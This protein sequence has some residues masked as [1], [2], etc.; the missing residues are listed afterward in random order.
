MSEIPEQE[1][2][3]FASP[4]RAADSSP[5]AKVKFFVRVALLLITFALVGGSGWWFADSYYDEQDGPSLTAKVRRGD[6]QVTVLEQGTLESSE[7]TEV[8]CRIRGWSKVTWIV[9][10]GAEVQ[11]GEELVRID[12]KRVEDAISLHTTDTHTARA[13]LE[14][15]KAD[16]AQAEMAEEA[17]LEGN[18]KTQLK[19][20]NRELTIAK[21]NFETAKK[22]LAHS[23]YMFNRGYVS[24]LEVEGN[25][26]TVTQAKLELE[27][28][29]TRLSVLETYTKEMNLETI[30]GRVLSTGSKLKADL[31]GLAM[32]EGRRD[33]AQAELD[34]CVI[35][36]PKS[37][38][39]IYPSAAAWKETPDVTEGANVRRDQTLLLMPDLQKMQVKVGIHESMIDRVKV[40]QGAR[41]T[42]TEGDI[43][44]TVKDVAAVA[45]PAGWWTGNMVKYD[46]WIHIPPG[47]GL[48]PGMSAEVEVVLAEHTDVLLVPVAAIVETESETLCW[49][50]QTDGELDRRSLVLGDSNEIYVIVES[51]LSEGE[52]VILNPAAVLDA[53]KS[54]ALKT[55]DESDEVAA[56]GSNAVAAKTN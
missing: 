32:D 2:E 31:A 9:E 55:I 18:Y 51:G 14:R 15:T 48:K 11:E 40:G 49:V 20:L 28:V 38:M 44:G 7:N 8:K 52:D 35:R 50:K 36:A 23:R 3:S 30:R 17:Y 10:S 42:L 56:D 24:E 19:S 6:L 43:N 25:Q 29:Q 27:V 5:S 45:R 34:M 37:G 46:T 12:T 21:S 39:V 47:K 33:R 13:T 1:P 41:I 54:E 4:V 16:V 53:A 26:F 22:M